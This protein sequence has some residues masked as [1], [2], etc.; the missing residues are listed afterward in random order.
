MLGT[1][2]WAKRNLGVRGPNFKSEVHRWADVVS[3]GVLLRKG[4]RTTKTGS[5]YG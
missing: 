4:H 1:V 2:C 3:L 5:G